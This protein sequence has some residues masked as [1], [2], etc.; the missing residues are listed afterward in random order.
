MDA[1]YRRKRQNRVSLGRLSQRSLLLFGGQSRLGQESSPDGLRG[2]GAWSCILL[3]AWLLVACGP[4]PPQPTAVATLT[5]EAT[6]QVLPLSGPLAAPEAELSGLAW[7]GDQLLLLPQYPERFANALFTLSQADILTA[8]AT[9]TP[10]PLVPH[11]IPLLAPGL[12]DLPGYEGLEGVIVVGE[13]LFVTVESRPGLRMQG[14]LLAGEILPD[15]SAARLDTTQPIWLDPQ[16][17]ISNFSDEALLATADSLL[18][19]YEGNGANINPQ[20]L[21]RRFTFDLVPLAPLPFP[22]LEYRLTDVTAL[23]GNGRF[24]GINY[25][26][27]G[28]RR[29][30]DPAPDPLRAAVGQGKTPAVGTAVERLVEFQLGPDAITL[31]SQP[32]ISLQLLPDGVARNWE[33]VVRLPEANGFLLVTDKFPETILAF[34]EIP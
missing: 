26:Y 10:D 31:T 16:A 8:L 28:E 4:P 7:Y 12:S 34:V 19:F 33:G 5:P 20:P 32:P 17:S 27:P 1:R 9:P 14:V 23:D 6:V 22:T 2:G 15:L 29:K 11:P 18:T 24:W 13:R 21:A 3:L 25:L 30:L